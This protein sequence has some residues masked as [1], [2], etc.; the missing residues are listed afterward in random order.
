M[1]ET[2]LTPKQIKKSN[3]SAIDK[4]PTLV[5]AFTLYEVYQFMT[6]LSPSH[7]VLNE[8]ERLGWDTTELKKAVK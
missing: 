7:S 4:H 1:K 2:T 5:E 6:I 8:L 3:Q